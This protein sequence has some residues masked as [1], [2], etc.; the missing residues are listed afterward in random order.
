MIN[1]PFDESNEFSKSLTHIIIED[2]G[3]QSD[4]ASQ[5]ALTNCLP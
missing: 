1:F 4:A 3:N 5:Y 2:P